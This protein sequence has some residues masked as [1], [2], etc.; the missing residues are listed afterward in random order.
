METGVFFIETGRGKGEKDICTL[1]VCKKTEEQRY[2]YESVKEGR[3][4]DTRERT[5]REKD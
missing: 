1:V 3:K 4:R 2:Y 5:E